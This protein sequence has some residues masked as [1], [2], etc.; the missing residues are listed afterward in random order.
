[1]TVSKKID[2]FYFRYFPW[3]LTA[4]S[5]SVIPSKLA[6][7]QTDGLLAFGGAFV[8]SLFAMTSLMYARARATADPDEI[9]LRADI[10]DEGL[11]LS[12]IA[13]M[14][15]IVTGFTFLALSED[16]SPRIGHIL[17][18]HGQGAEIAPGVASILCTTFFVI[19]IMTKINRVIEMTITNMGLSHKKMLDTTDTSKEN[20]SKA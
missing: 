4:V 1:M 6:M 13:V 12:L 16:Y 18:P 3:A 2:S 9:L 5:L 15:L 7:M 19:P 10:A 20:K 17:D 11:K 14:G 8:T